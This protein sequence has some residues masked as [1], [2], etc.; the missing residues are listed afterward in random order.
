[1]LFG[2]SKEGIHHDI[3][4]FTYKADPTCFYLHLKYTYTVHSKSSETSDR[5]K[6]QMVL[7]LGNCR[8]SLSMALIRAYQVVASI[9]V[10]FRLHSVHFRTACVCLIGIE[11]NETTNGH[12]ILF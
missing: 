7:S 1:M 2:H 10:N 11:K 8:D 12:H 3:I 6:T 5:K 4:I 9:S